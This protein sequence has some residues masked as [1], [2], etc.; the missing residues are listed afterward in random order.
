[1]GKTALI[2]RCT[3]N[4]YTENIPATIPSLSKSFYS[5]GC[6]LNIFDT[7]NGV[8]P[9]ISNFYLAGQINYR[10]TTKGLIRGAHCIILVYDITKRETFEN[11]ENIL[12]IVTEG[13]PSY[14]SEQEKNH[15]FVLVG[16]IQTMIYIYI[17]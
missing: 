13:F 11:L 9:E 3:N 5:K 16:K 15:F 14:T 8:F 2:E 1:M 10:V 7:G 12:K 4:T 17:H 6:T